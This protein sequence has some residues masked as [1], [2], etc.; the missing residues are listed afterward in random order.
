MTSEAT[1]LQLRST[2][3]QYKVDVWRR[4]EAR[5]RDL[6]RGGIF[7]LLLCALSVFIMHVTEFLVDDEE[8][9]SAGRHVQTRNMAQDKLVNITSEVFCG[10]IPDD[11]GYIELPNIDERFF[12]WFFKSRRQPDTDPLV[13]WLTRRPV[14]SSLQALLTE[15]GPCQVLPDLS[16]RINPYSWTNESNVLWLDLPTSGSTYADEDTAEISEMKVGEN[17]Y[18]FLQRF[19][20]KHPELAMRDLFITGESY[21][22]HY[23]PV[24]SHYVWKRSKEITDIPKVINLKGIS[25]GN[26][27]FQA[28][29]QMPHYLNMAINNSYNI[30]L[31]DAA[32]L[33]TMKE[34]LPECVSRLKQCPQNLTACR[35]GEDFC[36][37]ELLNPMLMADRNPFDIRLPYQN[38]DIDIKGDNMSYVSRYLNS[39]KI[40]TAL[41]LDLKHSDALQE[42]NLN[43]YNASI[44]SANPAEPIDSYVAD[45]LNDDVRVLVYAGDADL[46]SNWFGSEVWTLALKWKDRDGFNAANVTSFITKNGVN[47]GAVRSLKKLFTFL[48]VYSSGHFVVKDQPAVALDI[49][50]RFLRDEDF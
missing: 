8:S 3:L 26:S 41:N 24:V 40:Q 32:E 23:V 14:S 7:L 47:A 2:S 48:R 5:K 18:C 39:L 19:F 44:K 9:D 27:L 35:A 43:R 46:V 49:L 13:L 29:I 50:N 11:S 15:N 30:A 28:A 1:P 10:L 4:E 17:V 6:T 25:I 45:L 34:A 21:G 33:N 16:T 12:Y 38:D 37:K 36:M 20:A 22:G 31:V 42:C